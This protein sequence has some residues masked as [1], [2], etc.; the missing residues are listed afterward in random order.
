MA[1]QQM[2]DPESGSVYWR[3]FD[4][5]QYSFSNPNADTYGGLIQYGAPTAS[6][7]GEG[8]STQYQ[9]NNVTSIGGIPLSQFQGRQVGNT[10]QIFNPQ[11]GQWEQGYR[12]PESIAGNNT[13]F[14]PESFAKQ[15]PG[16]SPLID[17]ANKGSLF[18]QALPM[19]I[20]AGLTGG[21]GTMAGG[22]LGSTLGGSA[23]AGG[24]TSAIMGGNPLTGA[25]TGA[26]GNL[27][28]SALPTGTPT[29]TAGL[30]PMQMASNGLTATDAQIGGFGN[31]GQGSYGGL[32]IDPNTGLP[33]PS[34]GSTVGGGL[35]LGSNPQLLGALGVAG[36][37]ALAGMGGGDSG[38]YLNVNPSSTLSQGLGGLTNT[39]TS[40][41]GFQATPDAAAA[42]GSGLDPSLQ[43]WLTNTG[44]AGVT[45]AAA[46]ASGL[47]TGGSFLGGQLP[48]ALSSLATGLGGVDQS[49]IQSL[50][51]S[52]GSGVSGILGTGLGS[53]GATVGSTLPGL[54]ALAYAAQQPG[55]DTSQLQSIMSQLQANQGGL[56][57]AAQAP[58]QQQTAA[59][60]GDLL[61][62][63]SNRGVLGSSF[64]NTDISNYLGNQA[65]ALANAGA[66][67]QQG[68]LALQGN[69]AGQMSQLGLQ[70][71]QIRN[72]LYGKAIST[73]GRG[74]N[75]TSYIGASV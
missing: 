51:K 58:I 40:G 33:L 3:D 52:L 61:Q 62:R 6:Q 28:S 32:Q 25:L 50:I 23:L 45:N 1:W 8:G 20:G 31:V 43:S 73:L 55:A 21:L 10:T 29:Q 72:D 36:A 65:Q 2:T 53:G 44:L 64:A 35:N 24:A 30:D 16:S 11:T 63:L 4:T 70:N 19:L 66:N 74:L 18:E 46:N 71:Q 57:A 38:G 59:G 42:F 67:A 5:G 26:L 9:S 54:L 13:T 34:T 15:I 14:I 48:G 17:Q 7:G 22:L 60:Y 47:G 39:G 37:G 56:T 49:T 12:V 41:L 68:S 75:P 27:A 69:L